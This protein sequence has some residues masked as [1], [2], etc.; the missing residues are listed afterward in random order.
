MQPDAA[1]TLALRALAWAAADGAALAEFLTRSG[2]ELDDLR[3]RAADPE[4]LAAFMDFV[5]TGDKILT[6]VC[7]AEGLDPGELQDA[8]RALPGRTPD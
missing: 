6:A 4:L 3:A 5:L 1:E 8:R 7:A 2:L